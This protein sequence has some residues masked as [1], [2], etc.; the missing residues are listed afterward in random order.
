MPRGRDEARIAARA[1]AAAQAF[2]EV[3][4]QL[5]ARTGEQRRAASRAPARETFEIAAVA[6]DRILRQARLRPGAVKEG[7][8]CRT[9]AYAQCVARLGYTFACLRHH[10]IHKRASLRPRARAVTP[11]HVRQ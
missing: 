1:V 6:R 3:I 5:R 9:V 2:A 11:N 7:L 4:V 10:R 8:N